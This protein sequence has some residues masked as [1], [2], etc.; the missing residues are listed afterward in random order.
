MTHLI[1]VMV[2][3]DV[4]VVHCEDRDC[5]NNT[6]HYSHDSMFR[7][8]WITHSQPIVMS[9]RGCPSGAIDTLASSFSR[10]Q[11][12][13]PQST[14]NTTTMM[15]AVTILAMSIPCAI[16]IPSIF[17]L[18]CMRVLNVRLHFLYQ[19]T[20]IHTRNMRGQVPV[21]L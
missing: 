19:I 16:V 21:G 20:C 3:V 4:K 1:D 14:K 11:V 5:Q 18:G 7:M 10:T 17:S 2:M 13:C 8:I 6:Y 15:T 12:G 9:F